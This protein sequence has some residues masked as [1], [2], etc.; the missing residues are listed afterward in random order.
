MSDCFDHYMD[1]ME[2]AISGRT[3]DEGPDYDAHY[4]SKGEWIRENLPKVKR[5]CTKCK[6][7]FKSR[8]A[9]ACPECGGWTE[10]K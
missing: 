9:M 3:F 4:L 8:T 2:D 10:I 7:K 5:K 6:H 1:A